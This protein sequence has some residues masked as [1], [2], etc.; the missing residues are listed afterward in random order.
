MKIITVKKSAMKEV[1]Q[2]LGYDVEKI[3][4]DEIAGITKRGLIKKD[5]ISLI[6]LSD[7]LEENK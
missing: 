6:E 3:N 4:I 5:I 1:L 7:E 2:Y